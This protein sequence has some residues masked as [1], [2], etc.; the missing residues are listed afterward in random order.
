M[1]IT[2]TL[3]GTD[4]SNKI[5]LSSLTVQQNLTNEVDTATFMM[6][7]VSP[8][9]G[10]PV[11]NDDIRVSDGATVIFAGKVATVE[12]GFE[13]PNG[14]IYTIHCVDH[15]LQMDRLLVAR[16]YTN[17]SVHNIIADL[18]TSY[19][20]GFTY[21]NVVCDFV[22]P[23]IV[24]NNVSLSL[25]LRRLADIVRYDW[26][27]DENKDVHF[28]AQNTNVAPFSLTDTAGNHVYMSLRR[29]TDGSQIVNRVK[30]R[31]GDYDGPT[32]TDTI[33]IKGS[34]TKSL[35]MPYKMSNLTV[36]V[37]TGSGFVSK[38]VGID[39]I[40]TFPDFDVL[41]SFQTQSFRF[42]SALADGTKVKYGG[43]PKVPVG[44][45]QQDPDSIAL[46]GPIEKLIRDNSIVSNDV[47]RKR[48]AAELLAYSS[49]AVDARFTTYTA[50]L[51]AGMTLSV[52][53]ASL[54]DSLIIKSITFKSRTPSTFEY[55]VACISTQR[56]TLIDLLRA[57]IA[58][59]PQESDEQE[60][61]EQL[62]PASEKITCS[63]SVS[64]VPFINE[65]KIVRT[66]DIVRSTVGG[67]TLSSAFDCTGAN[68]L[69]VVVPDNLNISAIDY[70][71]S[72][73]TKDVTSVT[74]TG[75]SVD[76][77]R[78]NSPTTGTNN[79]NI[80]TSGSHTY[81]VR[82]YALSGINTSDALEATASS[83]STVGHISLSGTEASN[84]WSIAFFARKIVDF[85]GIDSLT[86]D[87]P[88][89]EDF[90]G[91]GQSGG[92]IVV[93]IIHLISTRQGNKKLG[94]VYGRSPTKSDAVLAVYNGLVT[95]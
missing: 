23:K 49:V 36:Q 62:Y 14:S 78:L 32:Y 91:V 68:A 66:L 21:A 43:N 80:T 40:D 61:S 82:A 6:R 10:V 70:N 2:V 85:S 81:R 58:P 9:S 67:T 31:G 74:S 13:N 27:V 77:W 20:S 1:A 89:T 22:I 87:S 28:F 19:A 73:L 76:I 51:R 45:V 48:A 8:I 41:H 7:K 30:V 15:T 5:V 47:A 92:T 54:N 18:V 94:S 46:Y 90:Q 69:V 50:G 38:T 37:D 71:G 72:S 93:E 53:P 35:V 4:V 26:Y 11:F 84:I 16:T 34:D 83:Q 75:V 64:N 56:Y 86:P 33:T 44:A 52:Q 29:T 60:I 25:C 79:L 24:F 63:D 57:I 42:A 17:T 88:G 3:N 12:Q 59:Q 39:F 65:L 55:D 95:V